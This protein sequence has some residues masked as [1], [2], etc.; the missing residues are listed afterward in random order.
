MRYLLQGIKGRGQRLGRDHSGQALIEFVLPSIFL[1]LL[2]FGLIDFAIAIFYRQA[3]INVS[4]EGSNI[5]ARIGA[6][7][8]AAAVNTALV[9]VVTSAYPPLLIMGTTADRGMGRVIVSAVIKNGANYSVIAQASQGGLDS[10][11]A[12]SKIHE[13]VGVIRTGNGVGLPQ[14]NP[15]IPAGNS[16]LYITEV[17]YKFKTASPLGGLVGYI[18]TNQLYD[19]AYF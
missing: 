10:T 9:T 16:T 4:R 17:Y 8:P 12:P 5:A 6:S 19:A 18:M 15:Q 14:T 11:T 13:G 2:L 3:M 7:T 1:I